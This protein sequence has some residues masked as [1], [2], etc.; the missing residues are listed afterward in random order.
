MNERRRNI[1]VA[2]ILSRYSTDNKKDLLNKAKLAKERLE[3]YQ[4][5]IMGIEYY[6]DPNTSIKEFIS[7]RKEHYKNV[8]EEQARQ[9]QCEELD[10]ELIANASRKVSDRSMKRAQTLGKIHAATGTF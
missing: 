3:K 1:K 6:T 2:R 9:Q 10:D 4:T 7:Y 8:L 5:F